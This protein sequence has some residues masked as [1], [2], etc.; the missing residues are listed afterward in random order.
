MQGGSCHTQ[1]GG[2]GLDDELVVKGQI[3][4][5]LEIEPISLRGIAAGMCL[6]GNRIHDHGTIS[7]GNHPTPWIPIQAAESMDLNQG[8]V[9]QPR[10]FLKFPQS[11]L[12]EGFPAVEKTSRKRITTRI[13]FPGAFD[14]QHLVGAFGLP[15][16][17]D[18]H[19]DRRAG[20]I[21]PVQS[22]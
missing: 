5:L 13:G 7:G 2:C 4:K 3:R 15:E 6:L 17:D 20:M 1:L 14:Q 11:G 18:I 10:F 12:L 9:G 16:E 19:C 8:D 22:R 21:I